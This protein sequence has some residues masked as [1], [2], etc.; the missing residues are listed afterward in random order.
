MVMIITVMIM[1]VV[2]VVL[3]MMTPKWTGR[4]RAVPV[5]NSTYKCV[6][7]CHGHKD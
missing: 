6:E 7:V 1:V 2:V 5:E 3:V 4:E